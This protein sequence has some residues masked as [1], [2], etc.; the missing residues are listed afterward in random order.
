M[1]H[2]HS[3]W[4]TVLQYVIARRSIFL[5]C[6]VVF[7]LF[8]TLFIPSLAAKD[9]RK[10]QGLNIEEELNL[11]RGR[12]AAPLRPKEESEDE[13]KDSITDKATVVEGEDEQFAPPRK[14]EI[15]LPQV[16]EGRLS[17]WEDEL[18]LNMKREKQ[19]TK[20]VERKANVGAEY[21]AQN[22]FGARFY[23]TKKEKMS[24]YLIRYMR[25]KQDFEEFN[26]SRIAH[27]ASSTDSLTLA[28]ERRFGT[29]YTTRLRSEYNAVARGL[30]NNTAY[31]KEDKQIGRFEWS[32]QIRPAENQKIVTGLAG[33]LAQ[34]QVDS[35]ALPV[36]HKADFK[37]FRAFAEWQYIFGE[38]NALTLSG[39]LFYAEN[40]EYGT[41]PMAYYRGG[42]AEVKNVFPLA[43]FV[44]GADGQALQIDATV[45]AKI[46]FAQAFIPVV[47]PRVAFDFFYPGYQST[48]E[49]ER[50]GKLPDFADYYFSQRYQSPYLFTQAED[51]WRAAFANNFHVTKNSFIKANAQYSDYP[52]YFDRRLDSTQGILALTPVVFRSLEGSL[53]FAQNIGAFFYHDTGFS[54]EYFFDT[55]SLRSPLGIFSKLHFK[56]SIWDFSV[57]LKYVHRRTEFQ[58][59]GQTETTLKSYTLL[60]AGIEV[61]ATNSLSVFVRGENLF[62]ERWQTVSLYH[63]SGARGVFGLNIVF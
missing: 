11:D 58:A 37:S 46:F 8:Y 26:G 39:D 38:R 7:T 1:P 61:Q 27:S 4:R 5:F 63:N 32:N 34:G 54:A 50:T 36:A 56:P 18:D 44:V 52:V 62:N 14:S 21:G 24:T 30:Q 13:S 31:D 20:L 47:G 12:T 60:N 25:Q 3:F 43:R 6:G 28:L 59:V 17:R 55:V 19:G 10:L 57:E 22:S 35:V 42:N 2:S 45:G 15:E 53:S 40:N 51:F 33:S 9:T 23:I 49:L 48:L 41:N 29:A 16:A